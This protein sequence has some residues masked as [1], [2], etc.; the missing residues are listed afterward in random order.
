[1]C[2]SVAVSVGRGVRV[3]VGVGVGV[4]V[5]PG[6]RVSVIVGDGTSTTCATGPLGPHAAAI[7]SSIPMRVKRENFL[8]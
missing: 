5:G 7:A 4:R 8:K 1:M 6:V 3:C 2:V